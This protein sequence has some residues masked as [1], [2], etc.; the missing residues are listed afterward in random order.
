MGNKPPA[1]EVCPDY[2][3]AWICSWLVMSPLFLIIS[4]IL[5]RLSRQEENVTYSYH[6]ETSKKL[7]KIATTGRTEINYSI[8]AMDTLNIIWTLIG[9]IIMS[10]RKN[11]LNPFQRCEYEYG[12]IL[13]FNAIVL[14][15]FGYYC[16]IRLSLF[17]SI[18]IYHQ[19]IF[20][21]WERTSRHTLVSQLR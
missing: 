12:Q 17:L 2:V 11:N 9:S 7:Y 6:I 15:M 14:M 4:L 5:G 21:Y 10:Y 8:I 13:E 1:P 3:K 18:L 16:I 19:K 20:G